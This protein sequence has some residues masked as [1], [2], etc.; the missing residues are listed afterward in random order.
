ML[1][2]RHHGDVWAE[3]GNVSVEVKAETCRNES[4]CFIRLLFLFKH[5]FFSLNLLLSNNILAKKSCT[6][7]N[8]DS[9]S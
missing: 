5:V 9:H 6:D 8:K 7:F 3:L 2:H 4:Q 1:G